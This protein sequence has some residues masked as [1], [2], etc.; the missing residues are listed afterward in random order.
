M[1]IDGSI[2]ICMYTYKWGG[3]RLSLRAPFNPQREKNGYFCSTLLLWSHNK[4]LKTRICSKSQTQTACFRPY[5]MTEIVFDCLD[6]LELLYFA[7]IVS[8]FRAMI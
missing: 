8:A 7:V 6:C 5:S 4:I 3:R 2:K 1:R